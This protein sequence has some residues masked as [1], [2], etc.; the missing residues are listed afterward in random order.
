M[1]RV[2]LTGV[3]LLIT[4]AA[5]AVGIVAD[6]VHNLSV[7]GPG[8][9]KSQTEDRICIYCHTPHSS[10][11]DAPLWNRLSPG[12][13][14]TNYQSSTSDASPGQVSTSSL[15]CLSCHDGTIAL[16]DMAN[17]RV[18]IVDNLGTT[19]LANRASLGTDLSDDHPVSIIYDAGLSTADPDLVHPASVN[20]P[21]P[22]GELHCTSCHDSHDNTIPPFLHKSTIN[23]EL[24]ITC[25]VSSGLNWD[26]SSSSHATSIATPQGTDPWSERKPE[27][28]GQTV[29]DNACMNCHTPHNATTAAR[30]VKDQEEQTCYRCHDGSVGQNNI[31]TDFQKFFRH[32]VDVT[33][34]MNHDHAAVENSSTM[35]LHVECQDCHNPHASYSSAPMI[36]FNP[37]NPQDTNLTVAPFAN[38]SLAGVKGIDISGS[39]KDESQ[40]E[41][42][43]CF[44]C[45]GVTG[46][47]ACDNG[48]CST[49]AG[50]QMVRQDNIYN[51]RDK[52][53][54]GNP[55][56]VSY[57]PVYANNASNNSEVPSLRNDI[58]LDSVSSQIYCSD[59]HSSNDSPAAGGTGSAGPHGSTYEGI[60]AQNYSFNPV[61]SSS[62]F[63]NEL[64]YKCHDS[65]N[66]MADV[67]FMHNIHVQK[68]NT[69]CI[70]CHDPHG[71]E[72][73]P[74]L[75]NFLTFSS[76]GGQN[77][78]ITGSGNYTQPT[79]IDDGVYSG[80]CYLLC[81]GKDHNGEQYLDGSGL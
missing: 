7:S 74:H 55:S 58:P 10:T 59:C 16:G 47:G 49:A 2:I 36:S 33:P 63:D 70:N 77:I 39:V 13:V 12:G 41:Y 51:I 4:P 45:H 48:R 8:L 40:Y 38:G 72:A 9:I 11:A 20:L 81:H 32:P 80:T 46:N 24:C 3:C 66:L 78:S 65:A 61:S 14:I 19:K 53:D 21:L 28:K 44:K 56:L 22:D 1:Y 62:A 71:S 64:C 35:P 73:G 30:L 69:S 79:W 5:F 17:S 25:H 31:Q 18:G 34:N 29:A 6:T 43:V 75:I 57:H 23:G 67:S 26:W 42:E 37:G 27:W 54:T 76:V 68:N 60:M 52:F 15:N 50:Y